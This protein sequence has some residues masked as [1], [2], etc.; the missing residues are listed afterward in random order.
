MSGVKYSKIEL[1]REKKACQEALGKIKALRDSIFMIKE[2][3]KTIL[4]QIP[5]GVKNSFKADIEKVIAWQE[6]KMVSFSEDMNSKELNQIKQELEKNYERGKEMLNLLIEIKEV[7]RKEKAKQLI[8]KLE[9]LNAELAGMQSLLN[10]WRLGEYEKVKSAIDKVFPLI[11]KEEFIEA[12]KELRKIKDILEQLRQ[13]TT[14]LENQDNLR[15]YVLEKL[16]IVCKDMGW[17]EEKEPSLEDNS[18]PDSPLIYQVETYYAG[19]ITFRLTLEGMKVISP[20]S[21]KNNT[22]Y[23]AFDKLS[24]GLKNFGISTKFERVEGINEEP[25]LIQRGELDLPDDTIQKEEEV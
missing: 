13:E 20:I 9:G 19:I 24:E 16:K 1:E 22:C 12:E 18:K 6:E 8:A 5:T 25:K 10:K 14:S 17:G 15:R 3:V 7:K 23:E 2:S 11:D 21:N 4:N